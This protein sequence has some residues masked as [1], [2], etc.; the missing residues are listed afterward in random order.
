MRRLAPF[1]LVCLAL[2]RPAAATDEPTYPPGRSEQVLE[3]LKTTLLVPEGLDAEHRGSLIVLLHGMGDSGA[4]LAPALQEWVPLGYLVCAP[5]AAGQAWTAPEVAAAKRIA[6]GL[7]KGMPLDPAKVHVIGFSNGGW[8]LAPLAFDD[9]LKPCSATWVAAGCKGGKPGRW[10][11]KGLGVLALAGDQ[12]P[13]A[14]SAADTVPILEGKVRTVEARFQKGLEHKW[15]RELMGY[16]R[17]WMGVQEGRF[18]AGDDLNFDWRDDL[19]EAL[20]ALAG[21]KK[22]GAFVYAFSEDEAEADLTRALQSEVFMDPLVRHFG[23]QLQAV[24]LVR[25]DT[26]KLGVKQTPAVVV[27]D[28]KG[29]VRKILAGKI[30]AKSLASALRSVAPDKKMPR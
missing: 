6:L 10:A 5:S 14:R 30:K 21:Q 4:N 11:K 20:G 22:G 15:P 2:A 17:W 16:L 12:D 26:T 28:A 7:L 27:L 9:D 23:N 29:A 3:G 25:E 18:R 24:K 13:N 8:N 19:D 1:A